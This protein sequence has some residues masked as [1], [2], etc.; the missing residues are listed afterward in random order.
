VVIA[1]AGNWGAL[2]R[3]TGMGFRLDLITDKIGTNQVEFKLDTQR[4]EAC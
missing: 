4:R 1:H 3:D 2:N